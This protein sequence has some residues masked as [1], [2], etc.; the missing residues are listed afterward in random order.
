MAALMV[1][2]IH[3]WSLCGEF[4]SGV[5]VET[6]TP[7][8]LL[9]VSGGI[10]PSEPAWMKKGELTVRALVL[11]DDDTVV[12]IVT[13]DF[14]GFPSALGDRARAMVPSIPAENIL[15]SASHTHSAPDMYGFPD[16][17][18]GFAIDLNYAAT[19]VRRIATAIER[20]EASCVPSTLKLSHERIAERIAFNYYAPDLY[21]RRCS[22]LQTLDRASGKP[23]ATLVNY[24]IH[25]EVLGARAGTVSPDMVWPMTGFVEREAGGTALFINGALG[26]M[27]TADVRHPETGRHIQ[28]WEECVRIG[29][30][31]G[32]EALR[33]IGEAS[34]MEDVTLSCRH[35]RLPLPVDNEGLRQILELSPIGYRKAPAEDGSAVA[36]ETVVNY[37]EIGP[38]RIIT[39]PGEAL[40]NIGFYLKRKMPTQYPFLF[41]LTNDAFGYILSPTDFQS[42]D[43]YNYVS[44]TSLGEETAPRYLEAVLPWFEK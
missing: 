25:P 22:V 1:A 14:L 16:S 3:P 24:A 10:G 41:G 12:A 32:S 42:F 38:A 5:A 27:V 15:I 13:T 30:L 21:D 37:L 40:P 11:K 20:A 34:A 2:V 31:L 4:Q 7:D 39:I 9:P 23:V 18:G 44:R 29:E 33:I 36:V 26:G 43:R 35:R 8:P 28:T 19:V 17:S 6:V